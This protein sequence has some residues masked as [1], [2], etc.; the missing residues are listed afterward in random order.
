M[1][2]IFE[3]LGPPWPKVEYKK[4]PRDNPVNLMQNIKQIKLNNYWL[5]QPLPSHNNRFDALSDKSNEE[6][7]VKTKRNTF[8]SLPIF[9]A[10][11]Q[12][13]QPLKELLVTVMGDDFE[14]QPKSPEK[15]KTIIKALAEKHTEFH[16]YQ[17]KEDKSF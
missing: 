7:G 5:N 4:C 3:F 12:N 2:K 1:R 16:T 6:E 17:P 13:I 10:G 11:V 14:L 15:Y 8:K 9:V